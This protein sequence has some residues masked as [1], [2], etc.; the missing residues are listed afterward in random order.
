MIWLL[1]GCTEGDGEKGTSDT[2][3]AVEIGTE[4]DVPSGPSK[5]LDVCEPRIQHSIIVGLESKSCEA[6]V[7]DN[8]LEIVIQ[9]FPFV[10][11]QTFSF[12]PEGEQN[13][14]IWHRSGEAE[15]LT[16]GEITLDWEGMW[17]EGVSFFGD[18]TGTAEDGTQ[19]EGFITGFNCQHCS[20]Q[21]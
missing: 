17:Q 16:S 1:F 6:E 8:Y 4:V 2:A 21:Q 10:Q 7:L 18:Y 13:W 3:D 5:A 19:L 12:G 15:V 14:A 9:E 20:I 11:E